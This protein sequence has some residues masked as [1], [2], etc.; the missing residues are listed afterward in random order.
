MLCFEICAPSL[1]PSGVQISKQIMQEYPA[2]VYAV[3][4]V[5]YSLNVGDN[6]DAEANSIVVR[7]GN[8]NTC[9]YILVMGQ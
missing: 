9:K 8:P 3:F 5:T 7:V 6:E 2:P 1:F 4:H